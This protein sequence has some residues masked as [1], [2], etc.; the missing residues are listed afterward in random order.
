MIN[1]LQALFEL[2]P[3][4]N[5]MAAI[6]TII[7]LVCF[8]VSLF[9]KK[10]TIH[11]GALICLTLISIIYY[12]AP[13]ASLSEEKGGLQIGIAVILVVVGII[14]LPQNEKW[15]ESDSKFSWGIGVWW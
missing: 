15:E 1:K 14:V 8:F 12:C 4:S 3:I 9:N 6:F 5:T 7:A 11:Y 13:I 10:Y 2:N